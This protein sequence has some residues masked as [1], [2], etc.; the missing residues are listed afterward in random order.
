M[1]TD[2]PPEKLHR[3]TDSWGSE[4]NL[5][6]G[7]P[8]FAAEFFQLSHHTVRN[9]GDTFGVETVHHPVNQIDFILDAKVHVVSINDDPEWRSELGV[10]FEEKRR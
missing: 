8:V 10:V 9:V 1:L 4:R 5:L 7:N 2:H 6:E 3:S